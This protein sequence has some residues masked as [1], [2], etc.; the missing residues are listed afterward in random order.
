MKIQELRTTHRWLLYSL[1]VAILLRLLFILIVDPHPTFAG[2]DVDWYLTN[3]LQLVHNI[4]PPLQPAPVFLVYVGLVQLIFPA[5]TAT[6]VQ[7]LRLLNIVWHAL[8]IIG[9]YILA[10]RY[11]D[12]RVAGMAAFVIA[13]NP[14][15]I[16]ECGQPLTESLFIGLLFPTLALYALCQS[17]PTLRWMGVLGVLFGLATLTRAVLLLF[18][19]IL[20]IHLIRLH[21]WKN[22]L[23]FGAVL[24]ITYALTVSTWTIYNALRWNRFIVGAEGIAAFTWM[25]IHGQ[26]GPQQVDS[27]VGN[28][29]TDAQR[30]QALASQVWDTL[31]HNLPGYLE[32]RL[33]NIAGA[34]L[35]PH[36]TTYFPGASL[37]EMAA[38]WLRS[39]RSLNGLA[40]LLQ[41]DAFWPKLTLYVFHFGALILGIVGMVL[42]WRKFWLALPLV[43]YFLYTTAVHSVLLAL[44]RY[45][46]PVQP[47]LIVFASVTVLA[48]MPAF[49]RRRR[50]IADAASG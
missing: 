30:N 26:A 6:T 46:F 36:S 15:F 14:I 39:D 10:N 44:P 42:C 23:R 24:M 18:P 43:G 4:A 21:G 37:K 2:G 22:G 19:V 47:V 20:L 38:S 41:A 25:G 17:S 3:G 27:A 45:L 33:E 16:I 28:P 50:P 13:I 8:M 34:Y 7:R 48:T 5:D 32:A 31:A 40:T 49:S 12:R 9:V 35:Q 11:F 1:I 29:A